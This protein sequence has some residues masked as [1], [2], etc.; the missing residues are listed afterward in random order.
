MDP[1][2]K[3]FTVMIKAAQKF[4]IHLDFILAYP[5]RY[6]SFLLDDTFDGFAAYR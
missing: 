2:D 6:L 3:T 1:L 4:F 5:R